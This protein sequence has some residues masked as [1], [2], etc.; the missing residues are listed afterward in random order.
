MVFFLF[1]LIK[2]FTISFFT[3]PR[4]LVIRMV[5]YWTGQ[6][7][8]KSTNWQKQIFEKEKTWFAEI[9]HCRRHSQLIQLFIDHDKTWCTVGWKVTIY[10]HRQMNWRAEIMS[11]KNDI[12]LL[13]FEG[14]RIFW[15]FR[16]SGACA[17]FIAFNLNMKKTIKN[18]IKKWIFNIKILYFQ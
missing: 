15:T 11:S 2:F 7:F 13:N 8:G 12:K 18:Q 16:L 3:F 4:L 5:K 9:F 14:F 10:R 1:Y 6:K 17:T